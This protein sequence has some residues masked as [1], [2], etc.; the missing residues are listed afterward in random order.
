MVF[1]VVGS[2]DGRGGRRC[3]NHRRPSLLAI[4]DEEEPSPVGVVRHGRGFL[5]SCPWGTSPL[6][7]RSLLRRYPPSDGLH[8]HPKLLPQLLASGDDGFWA[9][10]FGDFFRFALAGRCYRPPAAAHLAIFVPS[11]WKKPSSAAMV[12]DLGEMMGHRNLVLRRCARICALA[13]TDFTF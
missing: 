13:T 9:A 7:T 3:F 11:V 6:S 8:R 12:A 4:G 10:E 5:L 1:S 2:D